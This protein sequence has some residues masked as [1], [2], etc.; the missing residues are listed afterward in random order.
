MVKVM[1]ID[2]DVPM[3]R[4]LSQLTDWEAL[5]FHIV[6]Q[7]DSSAKALRLFADVLPDI[8][9][10]DIGLPQIDG[11]ELAAEFRRKKPEVRIL[12]LTCHEDFGYV[13]KALQLQADDYLVKDELT[14]EQL[15][16]SLQGCAA[17]LQKAGWK[18][19]QHAYREDLSRNRDLLKDSLLQQVLKGEEPERIL[20][21]AKRL[22]IE[23]EYPAFLL[24]YVKL[25]DS[26]LLPRYP[27]HHA[28]LIR[29]GVYNIAGELADTYEGLTVFQK[30]GLLTVL[31]NYRPSLSF[32]EH[33][34]LKDYLQKLTEHCRDYLKVELF[35][36]SGPGRLRLEQIGNAYRDLQQQKH[37]L[38]YGG[39]AG[40]FGAEKAEPYAYMP[41]GV[42]E[43][44]L[45]EL[46]EAVEQGSEEKVEEALQALAAT[47]SGKRLAPA[48]VIH[49]CMK[50]VRLLEL[51]LMPELEEEAFYDSFE[52]SLLWEDTK[53]LLAWRLLTLMAANRPAEEAAPKEPKLQAIDAYIHSRL[54]ENISTVDLAAHL[55]MSPSYFSRSFKRMTGYNFIDYLNVYKMKIAS[56]LLENT[57][58]TVEAVAAQLG[59]SDRTYFS[60]VFKRYVG[61]TPREY[62][63]KQT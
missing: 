35:C 63:S 61:V 53:D 29:Y 3:L 44:E 55:Y 32:N 4:Y 48:D 54:S 62:R 34:Y 41:T 1:L 13:K 10:T 17:A 7:T 6:A 24:G 28:S 22:G 19:E 51:Q 20:G 45:L 18:A 49:A 38:Y 27:L 46:T 30:D 16:R 25:L 21:Y 26:T 14:K 42:L 11:L 33:Q 57:E 8:V 12:F 40:V 43:H 15:E 5:G 47:A 59:Y 23:W 60:K 31:Y 36:V 56:K 58:A 52:Q 39:S 50:R 2:D 9:I 37:F